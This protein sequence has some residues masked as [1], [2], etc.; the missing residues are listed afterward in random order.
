MTGSARPEPPAE[1]SRNV[2]RRDLL[3]TFGLGAGTLAVAGSGGLTWLSVDRGVFA[4]GTGPAYAPWRGWGRS[5]THPIDAAILAANAHNTQ[6]WLFRV[7]DGPAT[8][9]PATGGPV[10]DLFEDARRG[11]GALDP[12]RREIGI[13]LGCALE[14]AALAVPPSGATATITLLPD[15]AD[16]TH[17]ARLALTPAQATTPPLYGAIGSRRTNRGAYHR[18]PVE[19]AALDALTGVVGGDAR[20][21]WLTGERDRSAFGSLTVRA[22]EAIIGDRRQADDDLAWYRMDWHDLQARR[23][24][25][26]VDASG[27]PPLIRTLAK[28]LPVS[29]RQNHDGWLRATRGVQVPTA[30]AFGLLT[31]ED[32]TDRAALLRTGR[33]WQRL[34][35]AATLRGL[36][37][38]PLCQTLE[39]IDRERTAGLPPEFST[40]LGALL[41]GRGH[42][43][44]AFRIGYPTTQPPHSPRRAARSVLLA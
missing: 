4:T 18:R 38:Q 7:T 19:P 23:D 10:I 25:I 24:G 31:V 40:E 21:I 16:P 6:P 30:A 13:S 32:P 3:R 9:G 17:V 37:A 36:A 5:G 41:A 34:H 1:P 14:N 33:A 39:R 15:P 44:M 20:L 22:T 28:L 27:Q 29:R 42:A 43:V 8:G 35:L 2:R 26:T 11:I 12:V